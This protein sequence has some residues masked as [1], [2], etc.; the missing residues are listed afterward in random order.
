MTVGALY[1]K[2]AVEVGIVGLAAQV[3]KAAAAAATNV[4]EKSNFRDDGRASSS[5]QTMAA[6][7]AALGI[8]VC[9]TRGNTDEKSAGNV[10]AY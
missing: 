8:L 5:G 2:L 1:R 10:C 4:K 9:L 7:A 3:V 6:G